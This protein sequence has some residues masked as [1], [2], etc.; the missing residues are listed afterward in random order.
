MTTH[1]IQNAFHV[2]TTRVI[3][4]LFLTMLRMEVNPSDDL[5]AP[6]PGVLTA[7]VYFAGSYQGAVL[8]E[9][10]P[11]LAF[12]F[13]EQL[14]SIERPTAINEDVR[15]TLGEIAN[16][17]GGNL[18]ALLPAGV[19]LSLPSVVQGSEYSLHVKRSR[20]VTRIPF[21]TGFGG[22]SVTFIEV[23]APS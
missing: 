23:D 20:V 8:M 17:I 16:M 22:F 13:T 9:C 10:S 6:H 4:D 14:M 3:S 11:D 12:H 19:A 18:K 7:V 2:E 1:L 21:S 5:P 15:D